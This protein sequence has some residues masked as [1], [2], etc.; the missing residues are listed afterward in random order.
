LYAPVPAAGGRLLAG[1]DL[2]PVADVVSL[3]EVKPG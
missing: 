1:A 2:E 3:V